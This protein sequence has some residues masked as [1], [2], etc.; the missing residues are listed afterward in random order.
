MS[1]E[2]PAT[3][4]KFQ[5]QNL[6]EFAA[7]LPA[8]ESID[9]FFAEPLDPGATIRNQTLDAVSRLMVWL[10]EAPDNARRGVRA[11]VAL[12]C[13]RP[14]L[15]GRDAVRQLAR[16]LPD[17]TRGVRDLARHFAGSVTDA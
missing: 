10:A 7:P 11:T 9:P 17:S 12:Y 13:L 3:T 6:P 2:P 1:G 16:H 15:A 5:N 8:N 14:E 4:M